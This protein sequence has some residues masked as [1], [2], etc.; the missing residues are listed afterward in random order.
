MICESTCRPRYYFKKGCIHRSESSEYPLVGSL[1]QKL[2][3]SLYRAAKPSLEYS[4][5]AYTLRYSSMEIFLYPS[6]IR[7]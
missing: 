5:E 3:V 6:S 1:E 4:M 7:G 2:L